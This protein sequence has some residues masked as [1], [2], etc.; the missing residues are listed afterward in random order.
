MTDSNKPGSGVDLTQLA[1]QESSLAAAASSGGFTVDPE[2]ARTA[3]RLCADYADQVRQQLN[4]SE[5]SQAP[6]LGSFWMANNLFEHFQT[7]AQDPNGSNS[8]IGQVKGIADLMDGLG[9]MF[10]RMATSYEQ[11]DQNAM[12]GTTT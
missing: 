6:S 2:A 11:T 10:D 4:G 8:Y 7:K 3:A 5:L 9:T 1:Q 12:P